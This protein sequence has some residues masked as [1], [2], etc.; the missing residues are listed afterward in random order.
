[1]GCVLSPHIRN[2]AGAQDGEDQRMGGRRAGFSSPQ[3]PKCPAIQRCKRTS[4]AE[5][6]S[7]MTTFR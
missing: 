3:G 2:E 5:R 7:K 6:E 4:G 1:M